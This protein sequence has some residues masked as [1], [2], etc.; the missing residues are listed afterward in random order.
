MSQVKASKFPPGA[1]DIVIT[2]SGHHSRLWVS[3]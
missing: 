3:S 2:V 1:D